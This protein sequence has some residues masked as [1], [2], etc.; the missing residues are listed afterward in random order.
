MKGSTPGPI[1]SQRPRIIRREPSRALW[2]GLGCERCSFKDLII[3]CFF[4]ERI[5]RVF[6][7]EARS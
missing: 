2:T 1:T 3:P 5:P 4:R 6:T 7:A